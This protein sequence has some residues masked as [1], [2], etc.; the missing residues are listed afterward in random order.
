MRK[1][2][3]LSPFPLKLGRLSIVI[4]GKILQ[5]TSKVS[6]EDFTSKSTDSRGFLSEYLAKGIDIQLKIVR[7][8]NHF[9]DTA[10]EQ[11]HRGTEFA[12]PRLLEP[13]AKLPSPVTRLPTGR[14][15]GRPGLDNIGRLPVQGDPIAGL[16][17]SPKAEQ[18]LMCAIV[19][20]DLDLEP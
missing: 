15:F 13:R 6:V 16:V 3:S 12:R 17:A 10:F 14:R 7:H 4:Y 11:M 19:T 2:V 1:G 18:R 9:K 5:A 8:A 20:D